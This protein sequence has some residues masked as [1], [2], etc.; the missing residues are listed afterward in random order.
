MGEGDPSR[1]W[2]ALDSRRADAFSAERPPRRL[3][4]PA[5]S[6][7]SARHLLRERHILPPRPRASAGPVP[8]RL[9]RARL[10]PPS[11]PNPIPRGR[12]PRVGRR[13]ARVRPILHQRLH[14]GDEAR[15][16][17]EPRGARVA[18]ARTRRVRRRARVGRRSRR[19]RDHR[20]DGPRARSEVHLHPSRGDSSRPRIRRTGTRQRRARRRRPRRK[21]RRGSARC[22]LHRDVHRPG[23]VGSIGPRDERSIRGRFR[24]SRSR[25]E[26]AGGGQR[27]QRRG[28]VPRLGGDDGSRVVVSPGAKRRAR[29]RPSQRT[30][31]ESGVERVGQRTAHARGFARD[32]F[33]GLASVGRPRDGDGG[34]HERTGDVRHGERAGETVGRVRRDGRTRRYDAWV[35]SRAASRE[36]PTD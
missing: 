29:P 4:P 19:A 27:V 3:V 28:V 8:P 7:R 12:A 34:S 30:G 32:D 13:P 2:R 21:T 17:P 35:S 1:R 15:Q 24:A 36:P 5:T 31:R 33:R 18:R 9:R 16:S 20:G 10:Q 23:R 22:R 26:R 11:R 25:T 14:R 6:T